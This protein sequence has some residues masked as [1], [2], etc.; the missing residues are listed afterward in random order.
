MRTHWIHVLARAGAGAVWHIMLERLP[1]CPSIPR[2]PA[3]TRTCPAPLP[4]LMDQQEEGAADE[5]EDLDMGPGGWR[6]SWGWLWGS[7]SGAA[8]RGGG[9]P[10]APRAVVLSGAWAG[11]AA[12]LPPAWLATSL[13]TAACAACCCRSGGARNRPPEAGADAGRGHPCARADQLGSAEA[14]PKKQPG[15]GGAVAAAE[16]AGGLPIVMPPMPHL[17][18]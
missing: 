13:H 6:G 15:A 1:P 11:Q 10:R 14:Q 4:Q 3:P 17:N 18:S 8:G 9:A 7:G 2:L 16:D 12:S 5:T